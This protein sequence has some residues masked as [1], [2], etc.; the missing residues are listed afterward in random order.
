MRC[1]GMMQSCSHVRID[2]GEDI[3]GTWTAHFSLA[4]VESAVSDEQPHGG[5]LTN[6]S[7]SSL[8]VT[9]SPATPPQGTPL[10]CIFLCQYHHSSFLFRRQIHLYTNDTDGPTVSEPSTIQLY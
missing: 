10:I 1:Q 9:A 3:L 5:A 7:F 6:S 2:W 8:D 4:V